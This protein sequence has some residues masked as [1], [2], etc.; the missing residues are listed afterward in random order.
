[1]NRIDAAYATAAARIG[2]LA[3]SSRSTVARTRTHIGRSSGSATL[4]G[5]RAR[6]WRSVAK[7]G[8][9]GEGDRLVGVN[10]RVRR[11]VEAGDALDKP[12]R[13]GTANGA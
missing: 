5:A 4:T 1:M 7:R 10:P 11:D 2:T 6:P 3:L 12:S 13:R 8:V 9:R